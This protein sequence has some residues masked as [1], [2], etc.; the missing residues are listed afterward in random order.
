MSSDL[1]YWYGWKRV[2]NPSRVFDWFEWNNNNDNMEKSSSLCHWTIDSLSYCCCFVSIL[3]HSY[4]SKTD[5]IDMNWFDLLEDTLDWILILNN[6]VCF[7]NSEYNYQ[8]VFQCYLFFLYLDFSWLMLSLRYTVWVWNWFS[9]FQLF[10]IVVGD[11]ILFL[12]LF[13]CLLIRWMVIH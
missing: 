11:I 7:N 1:S 2:F 12:I 9:C 8:I 6:H 5:V 3:Y 4:Y 10:I 13:D